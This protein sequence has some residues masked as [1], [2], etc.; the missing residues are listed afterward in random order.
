MNN[1][2]KALIIVYY[3]P[4]R[5]G[6]AVIRTYYYVK[7][8][9]DMGWE[10]I[11]LTAKH[12]YFQF[13]DASLF[14]ELPD[15]LKIYYTKS[16]W[17]QE[18]TRYL[19]HK[20][21]KE[22]SSKLQQKDQKSKKFN[23]YILIRDIKNKL[24]RIFYLPDDYIGWKKLAIKKA[25]QIF[26]NH[27][28]DL[29]YTSSP[30]HS[31]HLAGLEISK[32]FKVPWIVDFR[33]PWTQDQRYFHPP[34]FFHKY[35]IELA[36]R[37]TVTQATK[38]ISVSDAMTKYFQEKYCKLS[39]DKF[40][41]I[42]NGYDNKNFKVNIEKTENKDKFVITYSGSFYLHQTPIW[43]FQAV[44]KF[45]EKISG[46]RKNLI[47]QLVGKSQKDYELY[48]SKISIEDLIKQVGYVPHR[49]VQKYLHNSDVLLL[50]IWSNPDKYDFAFSGKF[51]EYLAVGKPILATL[52][53]GV[54]EDFIKKYEVGRVAPFNDVNQI[55]IIIED[56]Y[57]E[58]QGGH[59]KYNTLS[60]EVLSKFDRKNLT[61][62]L[63]SLFDEC[64]VS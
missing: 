56:L 37:L 4:P 44:K 43:F 17:I 32:K 54:C 10:P 64:I 34:T 53:Q 24:N 6:V 58:W 40:V 45:I 19:Q 61:K 15:D 20:W 1:L 36:E 22:D 46:A 62:R 5:G 39:S 48:P 13:K 3:F 35:K 29:I 55:A 52:N 49:E 30:P 59:L 38:V 12:K 11:I 33:D 2:K 26:A 28:I 21:R 41:T 51:F 60:K 7:Y 9:R 31:V 47:I 23:P 8:L 25:N 18:L 50:I 42:T 14:D 57:N 63:A 27:K 16:P